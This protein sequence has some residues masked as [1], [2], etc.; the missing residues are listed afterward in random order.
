M[1]GSCRM[2]V[3]PGT[4]VV[5]ANCQAHEVNRLYVGDS[6][7]HARTLSVNPSL[8][9]M[10]LAARLAEYLDEGAG[11]QLSTPRREQLVA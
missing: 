4:S 1:Q 8:T 6:S 9:I 7:L 11:G 2:G 3:D 5:D 10:A